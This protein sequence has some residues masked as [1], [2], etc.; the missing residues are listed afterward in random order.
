MKQIL[1]ITLLFLGISNGIMAQNSAAVRFVRNQ[2]QWDAAV[3]YCAEIPGGYLLLK[4]KSLM[5]VFFEEEALKSPHARRDAPNARKTNLMNG[6]SVEVLFE[7]ANASFNVE[8]QH[9]NPTT[10]NYFLGNDPKHWA[11]NVASFGEVVYRDVYP[12]IDFKMY[13]FRQTLKYEFLVAPNADASRI[14]M[15][16]VGSKELKLVNN[17]LLVATTVNQYKEAKPYTY[18]ELNKRSKEV[19]TQYRLEGE[20]LSFDF[21]K[22]YDRTAPLTIDPELVFS[23]FSGSY[24]NNFGHAATYDAQGNLYSIGTIHSTG[25]FPTTT[26]A[27]QRQAGGQID[28]GLLKFSPDGTK[29]LYGTYL[30]GADCDVPHSMIVNSKDELVVF[31]TTSS[32]NFPLT[33]GAYQTRF[34]G[35]IPVAPLNGF[36][37]NNGM[38]IFVLKLNSTGS[39]LT[40]STYVGGNG[41]DGYSRTPEF[42]IAN[43]GDEFR[44]EVV[45]DDKDNVYV[46][47]STNSSN[48]PL[49]NAVGSQYGGRQDAVVFKLSAD[50][51]T[52]MMSTYLGGTSADAAYGLKWAPSGSLYVTGVT[53]SSNLPVKTGA[54]KRVMSGLEDGFLAKFTNNQL[55]QITYMGADSADVGYLVDVDAEEN[56]HV[57]GL[58][59]GKYLTTDG[60]Y[61]VLNAGQFIHALDKSLNHTVFSTTIGSTRKHPDIAPTAFLVNEC[62]NIYLSGWGG[63]VN[64]RN[65]Y[66]LASSTLGL[67][68][69][70]DAFRRSTT[71][72]NFYIAILEKGAKS[73]LYGTFIGSTVDSDDG[74]HVDGGTSRF[75]KNGVIYQATCVCRKANFPSTPNVW[76]VNRNNADCN[77]AAFK[78]DVDRMVA[79]FDTYEGSKK[80]VV[81]GCA[82]LTL[83]FINTSVGGRTYTW[84][85]QGNNISRDPVKATY[86]FNQ[87]GEY[88]VTLRI[89]NPLVCRGQDVVTKI[90]KVGTTKAK[91]SGD[92]TVCGNVSVPLLAQGGLKYSWTPAASLSNPNIANPIAKVNATTQF[93]C[94]ITDSNCT[95][96]R[97]VTVNI[98]NDKADFQALKDTVI[99]VGQSAVLTALGSAT[100]YRWNPSLTLSDSVGTRVVAKPIQTTTYTV[101]GIYADGCLPQKSVTVRIEDAKTDFKVVPDTII[102]AGQSV[103]LTALGG[104][105]KFRWL[106]SATLS[107]STVRN[108]IVKPPQTTTYTVTGTYADG[109]NPKR[110]ITVHVE[111]GPQNVRF[112]IEP[113]YTCG[114]PTT[115]QYFNRSSGNNKFEWDLGNG[116]RSSN[117]TPAIATYTQNGTYQVTL[118]AFSAFGC[119]TSVTQTVSVLNLDKIPN[120]IT[121][122]GDG[123]NDTFVIGIPNAQLEVY[124]RWGK[125][126]YINSNYPDDWGKGVL[127]GTY[128]YQLKLSTT[129]QC[130]GW[131]QV[132][133]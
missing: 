103:Q 93:I 31:G 57:F 58:T 24:A 40:G 76:S 66:N 127:N 111:Q 35:G 1:L 128:F 13:A 120:V 49:V 7:D 14:K 87:P 9:Q 119:A 43:Y 106:P 82:P 100:R 5:Y 91:V 71:G 78:F 28:I 81:S 112:D 101:T 48:F 39:M 51:K 131:V 110:T 77:N 61:S 26:G 64:S 27:F 32:L 19:A 125:Q 109:C 98:R 89:A 3:R 10:Y 38:D 45:V 22:G 105:N 2:G 50:L 60:T 124:N 34:G 133:E 56:V 70:E 62:G 97:N 44:G 4:E 29:L 30:G 12:G 33:S 88:R 94:T 126:V 115:L 72:S 107:D 116:T 102:C 122:N 123:K 79:N 47:T 85:I 67:P 52:M 95:V 55:E 15:R 16:Y 108:P 90:I 6:H 73:L 130:K 37:F 17:E 129:V 59:L 23:T 96:T 117:A 63:V 65:A 18:Q 118:R 8:E 11:S 92:T 114:Q 53:R 84:D 68:T 42:T 132:I 74:D 75:S 69:T 104:A 83:D 99:C 46:A 113:I 54:F 41:S 21:P 20:H 25:T 86:T 36:E 121:P 80:D